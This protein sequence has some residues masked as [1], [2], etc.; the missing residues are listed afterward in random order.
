MNNINITSEQLNNSI[1]NV[2]EN[3]TMKNIKITLEQLN[4]FR[5]YKEDLYDE[6]VRDLLSWTGPEKQFYIEKDVI[7]NEYKDFYEAIRKYI[8]QRGYDD[9]AVVAFNGDN[10]H[11][12]FIERP[13]GEV[14]DEYYKK[15]LSHIT[16]KIRFDN[17]RNYFG[18]LVD[19]A[20]YLLNDNCNY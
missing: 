5:G 10:I 7:I 15:E 2:K 13:I 20:F 3:K 1:I 14:L 19:E 8:D 11:P 9:Y 17:A 16:K 18:R 4:H 12:D 6:G